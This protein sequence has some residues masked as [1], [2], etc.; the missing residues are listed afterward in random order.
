MTHGHTESSLLS[1]SGKPALGFWCV[2]EALSDCGRSDEVLHACV[3]L[4]GTNK[5][6]RLVASGKAL[7]CSR[8]ARTR[9]C[10]N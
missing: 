8:V 6:L 2:W 5:C 10:K 7:L 3:S 9:M 4:T 1:K